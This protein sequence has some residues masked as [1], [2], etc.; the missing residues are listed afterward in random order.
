MIRHP[1]KST[2]TAPLFPY[3]TL[4]RSPGTDPFVPIIRVRMEVVRPVPPL[5]FR[6]AREDCAPTEDRAVHCCP[7]TRQA[8]LAFPVLSCSLSRKQA[9]REPLAFFRCC[10][11]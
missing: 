2:L 1:P 7:S 9:M 6:Y 4:F 8:C 3:T 10:W 5:R 11:P